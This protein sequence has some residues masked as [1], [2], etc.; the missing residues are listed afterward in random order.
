MACLSDHRLGE[1]VKS[2]RGPLVRHRF[3]LDLVVRAFAVIRE[4]AAR[5]LGMRPYLVQLMG[6][7]G[8]IQGRLVEMETGEGKTL[9]ASLPAATAALAGMP[10]HILTVNDYLADRDA[11][12]L[13]PLYEAL[14][15]SVGVVRHGQTTAE[16]QAAYACDITYGANKEIAFDYLRDR[17]ALGKR[18]LGNLLVDRLTQRGAVPAMLLRGLHFAIVDE[19]D[20]ILIDEAR[21]PLIIS[22]AP[23]GEQDHD[24]YVTA[25]RFADRLAPGRDYA[26]EPDG[27]RIT[28]TEAGSER[29]A[30]DARGLPGVWEARRGRE[31]LITLA[32]SARHLYHR[33]KQYVVVKD[34]VQIVDEFTGRIADGR[35]WQHG[36]HQLMEIKE[37]CTVTARNETLASITYQRF[38]SRYLRLAGMSGT[39]SEVA[40]ELSATY[41]LTVARIPTHRPSRRTFQGVR[42]LRTAEE[43][44][45]AALAAARRHASNGRP[46]LDRDPFGGRFRAAGNAAC[47][48]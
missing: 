35:S 13:R 41:G 44:W 42:L 21:T 19:A 4:I 36:L 18:G 15:L 37:G 22:G 14:G 43:K 25:L 11:D 20:S 9:T 17:I 24:H 32:L 47:P 45:E 2:L 1:I 16:R 12:Q 28:L 23:E 6:G 10:T 27:R 29:V 8:L 3:R 34:K 5:Q 46:V 33:D 30:A 40:S 26:R 7:I 31:H 38:F 39:L 48:R